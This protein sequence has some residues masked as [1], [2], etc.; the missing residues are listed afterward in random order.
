VDLNK[1]DVKLTIEETKEIIIKALAPLG[2][3]Y[4]NNVKKAFNEQWIS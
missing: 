4:I 2:S 1:K 3:E